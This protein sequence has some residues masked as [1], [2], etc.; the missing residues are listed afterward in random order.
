MV[1]GL[2]FDLITGTETREQGKNDNLL[3]SSKYPEKFVLQASLRVRR[4]NKRQEKEMKRMKKK[5]DPQVKIKD[6]SQ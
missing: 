2:C 6:D 1:R 3:T 5:N 4:V